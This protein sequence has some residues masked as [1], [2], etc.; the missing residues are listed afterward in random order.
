MAVDL[1]SGILST[2]QALGMNPVDLATI[3]SYETAGTFDPM[4]AGPTTKWGQHRGLIQ[5]GEPQAQQFGVDF[6][7]P[8]AALA[9][10]FGPNGAIAKYFLASGWQPGMGM[11]DAY[12]TVNAGAPGRYN[13]SDTAAG[14]APGTV[15]DKVENQM[16]DHRRKAEALLGGSLTP[17]S[18]SSPA[19]GARAAAEMQPMGSLAPTPP[20]SPFGSF[21]AGNSSPIPT[22]VAAYAASDEPTSLGDR[23]TKAGKFFDAFT[24]DP[25][26]I[27]P[28]GDARSSGNALLK[29]L[30]APTIADMLRGKRV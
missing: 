5:F 8:D 21:L 11:L 17:P 20:Q 26:R 1:R 18:P 6:S 10:Q 28:M 9:S 2:A 7:S 16:E 29:Q 14:G 25:P 13:A 23:L 22:D 15:R 30:S 27:G 12:S 4:K 3:I 24:P 19:G